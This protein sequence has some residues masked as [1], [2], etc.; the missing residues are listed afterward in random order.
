MRSNNIRRRD[1]QRYPNDN[2]EQPT[3][4]RAEKW[5]HKNKFYKLVIDLVGLKV[6]RLYSDIRIDEEF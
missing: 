4:L 1:K 6:H 3:K 5:L 2:S